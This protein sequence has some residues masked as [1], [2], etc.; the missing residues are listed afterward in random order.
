MANGQRVDTAAKHRHPT[1]H[2]ST[3]ADVKYAHT[4]MTIA[5]AHKRES[6]YDVAHTARN[7]NHETRRMNYTSKFDDKS[8]RNRSYIQ[9][10]NTT[11]YARIILEN[12]YDVRIDNHDHG[13]NRTDTNWWYS[14]TAKYARIQHGGCVTL[15]LSQKKPNDMKNRQRAMAV[16]QHSNNNAR[17]NNVF[18]ADIRNTTQRRRC[19]YASDGGHSLSWKKQCV[20]PPFRHG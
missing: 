20:W 2:L 15:L 6:T 17:E 10:I 16:V 13:A 18:M 7:S 12:A 3:I 14:K 8:S 11:T 4:R 9:N 19:Q 5:C 1:T